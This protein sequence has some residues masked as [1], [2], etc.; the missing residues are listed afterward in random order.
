MMDRITAQN[1]LDRMQPRDTAAILSLRVP[2]SLKHF[3]KNINA[4]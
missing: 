3:D 4:L 1:F 2:A